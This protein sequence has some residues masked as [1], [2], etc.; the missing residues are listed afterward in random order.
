MANALREQADCLL[1]SFL[2]ACPEATQL[3][4]AFCHVFGRSAS[5]TATPQAERRWLQF[6]PHQLDH[7]ATGQT[8]L[9]LDGIKCRSVFPGHLDHPID[10]RTSQVRLTALQFVMIPSGNTN[11][12]DLII[13]RQFLTERDDCNSN[14]RPTRRA[15]SPLMAAINPQLPA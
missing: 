9:L 1:L 7:L 12:P 11:L 14:W 15:H 8:E 13:G 2:A 6:P 4:T 5:G 10:L 3:E